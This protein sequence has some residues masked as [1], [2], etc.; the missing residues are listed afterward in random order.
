M[1]RLQHSFSGYRRLMQMSQKA[2]FIFIEGYKDSYV[3][4]AIADRECR[5]RGTDYHVVT[6]DEISKA[7]GG[8]PILLSFF[9]Y[10]KRKS[11]LIDAFK[12]KTTVS[13]FFLDKDVD[14][15]LRTKRRSEHVVY[16]ETY[17]VENYLFMHG[18][19]SK[20]AAASASLPIRPIRT[21]LGDYGLWRL[22]AV[23]NW[24]QW[25]KLCLFSQT[26]RLGSVRNYG[27][28]TSPINRGVYDPVDKN[29]YARLRSTLMRES[30][31]ASDQ[32][33]RSFTK[34]SRRVDRMFSAGRYDVIFKGKWYACF[35]VADI[36]KIAK[37]KQFYSRNLEERLLTNLAQ[38]LDFDG[39]W[40]EHFKAP[41]RRL[42]AKAGI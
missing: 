13:I 21:A 3:Y 17:A 35:L 11:S 7:G 8:K 5:L 14:D 28:P 27:R 36:R 1:S 37:G 19:L 31:L 10:L 38:T 22:S 9:N 26:H 39:R 24:K 12:G 41:I 16:T 20:A 6:P 2:L 42:L 18:D 30:G 40:A 4:S 15:F 23:A 32:F 29:E 34:L 33:T 25:V